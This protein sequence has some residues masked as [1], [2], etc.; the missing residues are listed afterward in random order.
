MY[1]DCSIAHLFDQ[2]RMLKAMVCL[3]RKVWSKGHRE[4]VFRVEALLVPFLEM[5]WTL[6][7]NVGSE[8]SLHKGC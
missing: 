8:F 4:I 2:K 5:I 1:N 6:A 3:F 7:L